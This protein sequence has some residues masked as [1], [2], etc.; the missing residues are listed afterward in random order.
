MTE[1]IVEYS[2]T[3]RFLCD[4]VLNSATNGIISVRKPK[5]IGV[6]YLI[7]MMDESGNLLFAFE[8][9]NDC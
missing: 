8:V 2:D 7:L 3:G 6:N 9:V 5:V 1:D 4:E